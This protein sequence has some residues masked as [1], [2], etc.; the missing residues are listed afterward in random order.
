MWEMGHSFV[1]VRSMSL[2]DFGNIIGYWSEK[3]RG[4][5]RMAERRSN[6][7]KSHAGR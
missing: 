3:Q 7:S 5:Q 6:M 1:E 2:V 4:E